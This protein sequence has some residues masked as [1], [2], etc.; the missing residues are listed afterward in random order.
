MAFRK[1]WLMAMLPTVVLA[2]RAP[3]AAVKKVIT[4]L[5]D[6]EKQVVAEGEKEQKTYE[7]FATFCKE[8][9]DEK[10]A[11]IKENEDAEGTLTAS[12]EAFTVRLAALAEEIPKLE[13]EIASTE[14]EMKEGFESREGDKRDFVK[15]E[16]DLKTSIRQ[17]NKAIAVVTASKKSS[18]LQMNVKAHHMSLTRR[19]HERMEAAHKA[20]QDALKLKFQKAHK[21]HKAVPDKDYD[22]K[23]DSVVDTLHSLQEDFHNAKETL[24]TEEQK[25]S[26]THSK[27]HLALEDR[28][29]TKKQELSDAT[30]EKGT[31]E[32]DKAAAEKQLKSAQTSLA[33]DKKYLEETEAM[34]KAKA[35][36]FEERKAVR[37]EEKKA[38]E[39]ARGII[40][41]SVAKTP[42]GSSLS[43]VDVNVELAEAAAKNTN[44]VRAAEAEAEAIEA[45][46]HTAAVMDTLASTALVQLR[47]TSR[48]VQVNKREDP[49]GFV[50]KMISDMIDSKQEKQAQSQSHNAYCT[51][52]IAKVEQKRNAAATAVQAAN[53]KLARA[54]T[55]DDQLTEDLALIEKSSAEM[56]AKLKEAEDL[57]TEEAKEAADVTKESEDAKKAVQDAKKVLKDFYAG[58]ALIQVDGKQAPNKDAPDAGFKNSEKYGGKQGASEGVLGMLDVIEADFD[59]AIKETAESE[60]KA[61]A[62]L[63]KFKADTEVSEAAK[64]AEKEQKTAFKTETEDVMSEASDELKSQMTL[65]KTAVEELNDLDKACS[66]EDPAVKRAKREEEMASLKA[67]IKGLKTFR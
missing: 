17:I 9:E 30:Q 27:T 10:K 19:E 51:G 37:D 11:S 12:I 58:Q 36:T 33:D 18:L 7:K 56:A 47:G 41:E 16:L 52:S 43:S 44:F 62:T 6:L 59:R 35:D 2:D 54:Q 21:N 31:K 15:K 65:L 50:K 63:K 61:I 64:K 24:L 29:K 28:L 49:L 14:K 13:G 34:C 4:M 32:A 8:T 5:E 22:F 67:A 40:T 53:T 48:K 3:S 25:A 38:L 26:S 60:T 23:S 45:K 42:E 46:E 57:R 39:S 55:R 1:A 20:V 66:G